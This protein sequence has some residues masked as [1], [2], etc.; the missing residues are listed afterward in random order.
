MSAQTI[1]TKLNVKILKNETHPLI[2]KV[3]YKEINV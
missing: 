2:L 1:S 3:Y